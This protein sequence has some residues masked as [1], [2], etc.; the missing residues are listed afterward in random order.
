MGRIV[1]RLLGLS[2]T[3]FLYTLCR[4]HGVGYKDLSAVNPKLV[5]CSI[6]GYGSRGPW[7]RKPGYDCIAASVGG[8]M[9]A[10]GDAVPAKA[11]VPVTDLMTGMYAHGA[12]LAALYH[13][14]GDKIDC[15]L[16]STQLAMM[17]NLG[18]NYLNAGNTFARR[19]VSIKNVFYFSFAQ[20]FSG[21]REGERG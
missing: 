12:I 6:T 3:V 18:S 7:N 21:G 8:L 19:N 4:R 1:T 20:G 5:Y 11:A 13:G 15:D 16:L 14:T 17:F 10:T 9:D 2:L